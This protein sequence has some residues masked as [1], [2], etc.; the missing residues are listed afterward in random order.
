MCGGGGIL[1]AVGAGIGLIGAVKQSRDARRAA[2]DEA[3]QYRQNAE[4]QKKAFEMREKDRA[5]DLSQMI[6]EQRAL[7]GG[8]GFVV[9][10]DSVVDT[11]AKETKAE[12]KRESDMD[13][14]NTEN[15]VQDF[16][17]SARNAKRSGINKSNAA[18]FDYGVRFL[19]RGWDW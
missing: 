1:G 6:S 7:F 18:L 15:Q 12:F 14:F 11:L 10:G 9:E 5:V 19:D 4:A 17:V 8:S 2:N 13:K 3:E 16:Y